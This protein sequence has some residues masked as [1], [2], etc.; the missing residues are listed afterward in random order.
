MQCLLALG[1]VLVLLFP[2]ISATDDLHAM[3]A[4]VEESSVSKRSVHQATS[5]KNAAPYTGIQNPPALSAGVSE[6]FRSIEIGCLSVREITFIATAPS[7]SN[8]GR[9]PPARALA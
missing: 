1:C 3:R 8:T 9:A 4:E 5:E 2:V 6:I 7:L